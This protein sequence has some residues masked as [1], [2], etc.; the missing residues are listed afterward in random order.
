MKREFLDLAIFFRDKAND[1]KEEIKDTRILDILL[2]KKIFP[3]D[4]PII[5]KLR[6][7]K[8]NKFFT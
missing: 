5:F 7:K 3:S 8:Y 6:H 4:K 2:F 1:L